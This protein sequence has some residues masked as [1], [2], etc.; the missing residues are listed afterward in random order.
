[1]SS[2]MPALPLVRLVSEEVSPPP[3]PDTPEAPAVLFGVSIVPLAGINSVPELA[4]STV[5]GKEYDYFEKKLDSK[6]TMK[7]S[8]KIVVVG[9]D[10]VE[11][12]LVKAY[13][14][15]CSKGHSIWGNYNHAPA[16]RCVYCNSDA[17][18]IE[19]GPNYF[20]KNEWKVFLSANQH[21]S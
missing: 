12:N 1:M 16:D 9:K 6:L 4:I 11:C 17:W 18:R 15:Q 21:E 20:T 14:H 19:F 8:T 13:R 10:T 2:S 3:A 7:E 5:D